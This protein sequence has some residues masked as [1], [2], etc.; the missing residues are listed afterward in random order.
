[1]VDYKRARHNMV[2][3]QL[4][5]NKVNDQR[6]LR[7]FETLPRER[8]VPEVAQG[9]AYIDEDLALTQQRAMLEPLVLA[10]L[11]QE[12]MVEPSDIVLDI[13]CGSGYACAVLAS[14]AATVIGVE[15]DAFLIEKGSRLLRE[16]DITNAVIMEGELT[17][18]AAQHGP[19]NVILIEGAI[20]EL[21]PPLLDQLADGG[22]LATVVVGRDGVGR[23][24][25][26][27]RDGEVVSSRE[28]F[29]ASVTPLA[30]FA[31]PASFVF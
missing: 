13:A 21:S 3:S 20:E 25:L 17:D 30:G 4:R 1:M 23:A 26:F 14:L 6:I 9:Y 10:R 16:L 19:Y 27:R 5:T 18:G 24:T 12:A 7:A 28:L 8:F 15:S 2:E 29:D 22:R 11:V 31:K